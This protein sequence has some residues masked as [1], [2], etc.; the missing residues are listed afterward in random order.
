VKQQI[1]TT[2]RCQLPFL[3]ETP[4]IFCRVSSLLATPLSF[5]SS[6]PAQ[7]NNLSSS[8][9]WDGATN[10]HLMSLESRSNKGCEPSVQG[11]DWERVQPHGDYLRYVGLFDITQNRKCQVLVDCDSTVTF[12][13]REVHL[14]CFNPSWDNGET[15]EMI[16]QS[17][18]VR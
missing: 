1:S 3:S 12:A 16:F 7:I 9:A 10:F 13:P 14:S 2:L 5:V 17:H 11:T 8:S 6:I 18:G 15:Y 4:S